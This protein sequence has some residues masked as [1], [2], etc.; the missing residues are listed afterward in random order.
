MSY[1]SGKDPI[2]DEMV[3]ISGGYPN[4]FGVS[5]WRDPSNNNFLNYFFLVDPNNPYEGP[6][7]KLHSEVEGL[8]EK[9]RDDGNIPCA[10]GAWNTDDKDLDD[11]EFL[12]RSPVWLRDS[13]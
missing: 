12:E 1:E 10:I 2:V 7:S 4:V 13:N 9:F 8:L 5:K 6:A 11:F 3:F